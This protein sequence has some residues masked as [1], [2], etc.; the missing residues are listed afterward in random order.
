M[1]I[2]VLSVKDDLFDIIT[3]INNPHDGWEVLKMM[4]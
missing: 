3:K 1:F 4:F 2:L